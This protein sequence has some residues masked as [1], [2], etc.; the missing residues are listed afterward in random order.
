VKKN[1]SRLNVKRYLN[2]NHI[3]HQRIINAEG[4]RVW[5]IGKQ[6]FPSLAA[7]AST[8]DAKATTPEEKSENEAKFSATA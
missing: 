5:L 3:P 4:R 6:E 8:F 1:R 2:K 7:F